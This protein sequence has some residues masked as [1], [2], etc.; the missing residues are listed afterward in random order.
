MTQAPVN[1]LKDLELVQCLSPESQ[2]KLIGAVSLLT[3]QVGQQIVQPEVIP[4]RILVM[5]QG[6]ARLVGED[7]GRVVSLGR[8]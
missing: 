6:R 4:G 7:Q 8:D 2:D 1:T 3:F 5:L